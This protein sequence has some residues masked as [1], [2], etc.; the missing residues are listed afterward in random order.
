MLEM[1]NIFC[2]GQIIIAD[3]IV[4]SIDQNFIDILGFSSLDEMYSAQSDPLAFIAADYS[5]EIL[6]KSERLNSGSFETHGNVLYCTKKQGQKIAVFVLAQQINWKKQ[7]ALELQIFDISLKISAQQLINKSRYERLVEHSDQG[8]M[9]HRNF[10]PLLVNQVWVELMAAKSIQDVIE[11]LN[12]LDLI[13]TEHHASA[14]ERYQKVITGEAIGES[15]IIENIRFDGIKRFFNIYDHAI[16]WQGEPAVEVVMVDVTDKV[17]AEK[18]LAHKAFH[19]SLTD[20]YN[21]DAIYKWIH[22]HCGKVNSMS[23]MLIDLDNFKR[24]NDTYGHS[25]GDNV[26]KIFANLF[27]EKIAEKGVIGRWG[28]E[29]FIVF[30][31]DRDKKTALALAEKVR[32]A[33]AQTPLFLQG[34]EIIT[35]VSIG[36]SYTDSFA[37]IK[38]KDI[39]KQADHNMYL[40]KSLGKNRVTG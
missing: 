23:C 1:N 20:L 14:I 11:N 33:C 35:T 9:I 15:H 5:D 18:R 7:P 12:I 37:Q 24:V 40:S 3:N 26:L 32:I 34:K 22:E 10:K 17:M 13:P 36:V 39:I 2:Y 27:K 19:D 6:I 8:V 4:V 30:V 38:P 28:G 16:Q 31:P 25:K 29:E 21:R